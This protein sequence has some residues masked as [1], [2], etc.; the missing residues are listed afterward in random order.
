[1][2]L[3][4]HVLQIGW[5][6]QGKLSKDQEGLGYSAHAGIFPYLGQI[7]FLFIA[8]ESTVEFSNDLL[9]PNGA[10]GVLWE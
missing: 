8:I 6:L 3:A 4:L 7:V 9:V 10:L 2:R 5:H 1:M